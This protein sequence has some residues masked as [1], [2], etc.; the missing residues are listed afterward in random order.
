MTD[1][2]Q[3]VSYQKED[4]GSYFFEREHLQ[5]MPLRKEVSDIICM[6]IAESS[7]TLTT[8]GPGISTVTFNFK[9]V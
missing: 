2:I 4:K 3:E 9:K 7:G 1:F 6:Q 8:F 5:Y